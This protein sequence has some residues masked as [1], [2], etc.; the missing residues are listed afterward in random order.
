MPPLQRS[1]AKTTLRRIRRREPTS[2]FG[3]RPPHQ[4][5]EPCESESSGPC[6]RNPTHK[7]VSLHWTG[8]RGEAVRRQSTNVQAPCP[9]HAFSQNV[10]FT[11]GKTIWLLEKGKDARQILCLERRWQHRVPQ[12]RL[13]PRGHEVVVSLPG[14]MLWAPAAGHGLGGTSGPHIPQRLDSPATKTQPA[15]QVNSVKAEKP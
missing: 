4:Q 13:C 9:P 14:R 6:T 2:K 10:P 5:P 7:R 8:K 11:E 3:P 1:K 12:R 15:S